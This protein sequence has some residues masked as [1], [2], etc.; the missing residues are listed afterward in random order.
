MRL[1][2]LLRPRSIAILGA[3]ER[4]S[5]SHALMES[6]AT[7]GYEGRA[8]PDQSQVHGDPRAALLSEHAGSPRSSPTSWRCASPTR[9]WSRASAPWPTR[10]RAR[11]RSD[12]GFAEHGDE[13]R[14]R[15]AELVGMCREAEIALC[16]PNCMG[17]LNPHHPSWS[18]PGGARSRRPCRQRGTGVSERVHLHRHAG[19]HPAVRL[20]PRRLLR[21]RSGRQHGAVP[22]GAGRRSRHAG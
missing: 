15:Q 3:S 17:I 5:M 11:P 13:G 12:G 9:V 8:L 2:A 16:G 14:R 21:Q 4:P 7:L 20:Q 18:P 19:R 1:D 10:A 6:A 22:G